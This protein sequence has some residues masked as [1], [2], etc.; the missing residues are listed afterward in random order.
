VRPGVGFALALV[1]LPIAVCAEPLSQP[2]AQLTYIVRP[3]MEKGALTVVNVEIRFKGSRTG[4]TVIDL[5]KEW[6]GKNKLYEALSDFS[7]VGKNATIQEGS[8]PW[9]RVVHHSPGT[10]L[11][12][13][14]VVHHAD[15]GIS[16]QGNPYRP[17]IWRSRLQLLGSTVFAAPHGTAA[18]DAV[19]VVF[20]DFPKTWPLASDLQRSNLT[21]EDLTDSIIVGGDFRVLTRFVRGAR[22]RV[23]IQGSWSFADD[24]LADTVAK[25]STVEHDFWGDTAEPYLVTLLQIESPPGSTSSGG[26]GRRGGF[27]LFATPNVEMA[28][29]TRTLAH[30]MLHTWIP[31]RIGSMPDEQ[32]HASSEATEYWISE[33]F[34]DYF[35]RSACWYAQASGHP[36]SSWTH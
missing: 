27:A 32:S 29:L 20:K 18:A 2:P 13:R 21:F 7:V 19:A 9:E 25:I 3:T 10:Y 5:P 33:G 16:R 30:E 11:R 36:L 15:E 6:G 4:T 26:T 28:G 31:H 14:Y 35:T 17:T 22:L 12:V 1:L 8:N 24:A 34:D 23:A